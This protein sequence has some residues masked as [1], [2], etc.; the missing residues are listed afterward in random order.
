VEAR[1]S[2]LERELAEIKSQQQQQAAAARSVATDHGSA[3]SGSHAAL[4]A[5]S[6]TSGNYDE[7]LDSDRTPD[8]TDGVGTVEFSGD[9]TQT[10]FGTSDSAFITTTCS[11]GSLAWLILLGL[12]RT[13]VQHCLYSNRPG[14]AGQTPSQNTRASPCPAG[15]Q[16]P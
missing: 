5:D 9:E 1:F 12:N 6:V 11:Q 15:I 2:L 14:N 10:Y 7:H 16:A 8:A 13:L 4:G 3:T